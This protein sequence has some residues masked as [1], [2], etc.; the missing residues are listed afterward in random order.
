[1]KKATGFNTHAII[2]IT[3]KIVLS[4]LVGLLV[5]SHAQAQTTRELS[6]AKRARIAADVDGNRPGPRPVRKVSNLGRRLAPT[7]NPVIFAYDFLNDSLIS[8]NANTPET[9]L[10]EVPLVGLDLDNNEILEFIDFRPSDGVLYGVVTNDPPTNN[11]ARVV[12]INTTTGQVTN[13]GGTIPAIPGLFRGG[14]F[15]PIV[16]LIREVTDNTSKGNR[17]LNP[18][19]GAVAGTDTNLAYAAGDVNEGANANIVH[20]A[21]SN[22]TAGAT[23]TT[24]YGIDSTRDTLVTIGSVNGTPVSPNTGQIFTVGELGENVGSFGGF[25]IEPGTNIGYAAFRISGVSYLYSIDLA[26]GAATLINE[27]APDLAPNVDGIAIAFSVAAPTTDLS[28]TK[29]NGTTTTTAG[30]TTTY[31]IVATNSGPTA[32]TGATV[33]DNLPASITS[34][35]WTCVGANGGT[36]PANGTGNINAAVD[37][38]AGAS[39]TFTLA[40]SVSVSATGDL[41]NTVTIATPAGVTDSA[42]ANNS[43]TDTDTLTPAGPTF[44]TVGGRVTSENGRSIRGTEVTITG[45]Q[46][47]RRSVFTSSLGYFFFEGILAGQTY[48]ISVDSSRRYTFTSQDVQVNGNLDNVNFVGQEVVG[49]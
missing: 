22:N 10:T 49:P 11:T 24:L 45:P 37:L 43:A 42:P 2:P 5:F 4:L 44:V 39:V 46:N 38:P 35:N 41:V 9:L 34:A 26:T 36:C 47:F 18:T 7:A 21:Y 14:D 1:M 30:A 23:Q 17:R 29:T 3:K 16:D 27:I 48:T 15:N 25:D 8:F 12:T 28:I 33:I 32:V 40:A 19:T 13:V 31:T 6:A 20:V